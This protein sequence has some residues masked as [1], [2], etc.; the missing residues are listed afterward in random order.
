M[1]DFS[2]N[3]PHV[4]NELPQFVHPCYFNFPGGRGGGRRRR[5]KYGMNLGTLN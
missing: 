1:L 3:R 4:T 2:H 5:R